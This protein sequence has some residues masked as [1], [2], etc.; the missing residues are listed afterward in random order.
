METLTHTAEGVQQGHLIAVS[1]LIFS[2]LLGWILSE[3]HLQ[4]LSQHSLKG[5]QH[6]LPANPSCRLLLVYMPGYRL[7]QFQLT[8]GHREPLFLATPHLY[9]TLSTCDLA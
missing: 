3:T 6:Q 9:A 7:Q 4:R 5:A 8:L 2:S 1:I